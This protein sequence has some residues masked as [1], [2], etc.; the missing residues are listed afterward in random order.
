[1]L[2]KQVLWQWANT[3]SSLTK[4]QVLFYL[5]ESSQQVYEINT[6]IIPI[7]QTRKQTQVPEA[8]QCMGGR[9]RIRKQ[10]VSPSE[11]NAA[12]SIGDTW[13]ITVHD[14]QY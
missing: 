4:F 11:H 6:I 10:E 13:A 8:E 1:M 5:I 2:G 12:V 3:S 9:E 7:L 14:L